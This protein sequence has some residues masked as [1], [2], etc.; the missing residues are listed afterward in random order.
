M[1]GDS[2]KI[3]N[4]ISLKPVRLEDFRCSNNQSYPT[5]VQL[6][7]HFSQL[8]Q[9]RLN[10]A[11]GISLSVNFSSPL[12]KLSEDEP[13]PLL[14]IP[15][16]QLT[17]ESSEDGESAFPWLPSH[18]QAVLHIP[19]SSEDIEM[20]TNEEAAVSSAQ[21][22]PPPSAAAG[23]SGDKKE[24]TDAEKDVPA[25][26]SKKRQ[27]TCQVCKKSYRLQASLDK[28]LKV[29]CELR[30][31]KCD[32]C[33][34]AFKRPDHLKAHC[35]MHTGERPFLC[36][37][38]GKTFRQKNHLQRHSERK[39][40]NGQLDDDV[41]DLDQDQNSSFDVCGLED[42]EDDEMRSEDQD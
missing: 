13:S 39:H 32:I 5:P 38:C 23:D 33:Q 2:N 9:H 11:A 17:S 7:K 28:H 18:P 30:P 12:L 27:H 15:D 41:E 14:Q 8:D 29:P 26:K 37:L 34:K 20:E 21:K 42:L 35:R 1:P 19:D 16:W 10:Y 22:P 25:T 31:Y 3:E 36:S 4:F 24:V 40:I 6:V